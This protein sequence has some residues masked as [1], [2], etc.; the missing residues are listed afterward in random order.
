LD[1]P[2]EKSDEEETAA[3][4]A[5]RLFVERAQAINPDFSLDEYNAA[6]VA[7]I[8]RRL[9][10]LPLALELAAARTRLLGPEAMLSRIDQSLKLL[11]GGSRDVP[12]RHQTLRAAIDWSYG[13]LTGPEKKLFVRM[14]TFRGGCTLEAAEAVCN[15]QG[16]LDL[17]ELMTSLLEKSLIKHDDRGGEPR[18]SMLRIVWEY[19]RELLDASDEADSVKSDHAEFFL[20]LISAAYEGLRSSGQVP[21]LE[22][23]ES[24]HG[25][26][27]AALRWCLESDDAEAVAHA[28]WT[29]WL[30]WWLHSYLGEGRQLASDALERGGLSEIGRAKA[31]AVQGCMAFWQ[32][33]YAEGVPLLVGAL[34]VFSAEGDMAGV[35]L[36][37]LPLGFAEAAG[38]SADKAFE[39]YNQSVRFFKEVGDDWGVAIA[40]N[41]LCWAAVAADLPVTDDVFEEAVARAEKL[42]T[43]LDLGM[44]LRNLGA[45]RSDQGFTD[46]ARSL[47][48]RSIRT[49]WRGYPRGGTLYA[50]DAV[51]E[52]AAK[53]G[54][55]DV[56]AR[57]FAATARVRREAKTSIIPMFAPR[58]ERYLT[59][60]R[61]DMGEEAFDDAWKRGGDLGMDGTVELALAWAEDELDDVAHEVVTGSGT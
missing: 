16:D 52:I 11:T 35:A 59:D 25:N 54:A 53:E 55:A 37:Q 48:T 29:I 26:L 47:L 46:E 61:A 57:L 31:M 51:G 19:A 12:E 14:A 36:C 49:L 56:A 30:F 32:A 20:A 7:E 44:A 43:E 50:I 17:I 38:G 42:G 18:F 34:E 41:A 21:W 23:L 33:D 27:R 13:L 10:G 24:D 22:R 5:V 40:M 39:R 6:A 60:L 4:D 3:S 8:C 9:D 28:G 58:Y 1:L 45:R 2:D 15:C